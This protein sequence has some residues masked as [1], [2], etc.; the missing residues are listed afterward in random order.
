MMSHARG[1]FRA[2]R[3]PI[4]AAMFVCAAVAAAAPGS[5][6]AESTVAEPT[7]TDLAGGIAF[8]ES[9]IRPILVD[10]CYDCHA[11]DTE[12]KGSLLLDTKAGVLK[13]GDTGPVMVP[14]DPTTSLIIQ[15]VKQQNDHLK[16][17]PDGRLSDDEIAA[18]EEW[19]KMGAPDPRN[20]ARALT[21][22]E[23]HLEDAKTHWAFQPVVDPEAASLDDL[24][25]TTGAAPAD[26]RTL[27]RR[28]FL[29]LVGV[30]PTFAE[31]EAF[32]SDTSPQA[33]ERL[34]DRLL[35]DSRYG[36]R[37]G[38][39]WLDVARYADNGGANGGGEDTMP[40]AWTYR[41]YVVQAFN[42]DKPFDRF[43]QEQI[44]ADQLDTASDP[45][46]LAGL[47]FLTI[48]WRKDYK[49]DDDTLDNAL[50][51][52]GR[53]ILGLTIS[54]AR[55]HDH[56]LEPITTKDYYGLFHV[57]K[58]CR[59]PDSVPVL[60]QADS[61]EV[62]EFRD[63]NL[64]LRGEYARLSIKSA[65]D[66]THVARGRLG[67][68]LV[69]A[70]ESGWKNQYQS[71]NV[72]DLLVKRNLN[73]AIHGWFVNSRKPWIEQHP[74][75]F[76]P[77]LE[78][79]TK[80]KLDPQPVLHRLVAE[81]FA[82][83]ADTLV[84]VGRRYNEIFA[85]VDG[86]WRAQAAV[87]IAMPVELT[88]HEVEFYGSDFFPFVDT[89]QPSFFDRLH[90]LEDRLPLPDPM[91]ESLRQVLIAKAS[92]LRFPTEQIRSPRIIPANDP[93]SAKINEVVKLIKEHPGAP[94]RPMVFSD[95]PKPV[96]G[97]VYVR[98]NPA[99]AG[100]EAPR[101]FISVLRDV[102]PE[103]FPKDSSGRLEL[104]LAITSR[105]NP[106]T[107]RVIVN[108][109]WAWHFGT[110]LVST[111]SD[112]GFQGEK[113][114]NPPL[115]DHLAAWF[116]DHGWS[117][118]QMH[119]Y[120][121]LTAGYQR[122]DFPVRPLEIE[123]FRDSLLAVSG[124][125][126]ATPFGKSVRGKSDTR[127]TLYGY[128]D[129]KLLPSLYRSFDFPNPTFSNAQ[130]SRSVLV[131][132][133]LILMNSP[134]LVES[135]KALAAAITTDCADDT[136]RVVE[137]YRRVLQRSPDDAEVRS[138]LAYMAAYPPNDLVHPE[139]Q[140][141]QY[142]YGAF[143]GEG[144][145]VTTFASIQSFDGKAFKTSATSGDGKT[146]GVMVDAMG[147]DAGPGAGLSSIRRWVA[148]HDGTVTITAELTHPDTKTEGVIAR[149]IS[150]RTGQL[151]EWQAL[152]QS[153][154][155]N[156]EGVAVK[157]GD[158]IDFVVSSQTDKD[159]GPYRWS[160]SILMP[161]MEMPSMPGM[162]RRWDARTDFADP[163]KP[164]KPLTALEELCQAILLSPEFAVLE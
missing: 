31:V 142:G 67:E 49:I 82:T 73:G 84:E 53:G 112:F 159:A 47:A 66:A 131:P 76:G 77:Y 139:S 40:F 3:R 160:P 42:D 50:D 60:P 19:V 120:L 101:Q 163:A 152:G 122:A 1:I 41:D 29:D 158:T 79:I 33:F 57:L 143:D 161:G 154:V 16:M 99:I 111:P 74:E 2:V 30:P 155:T 117:L 54:C 100:P 48:G 51:T 21:K 6:A 80:Q 93:S 123:P 136:S 11:A 88:P 137:L 127:R 75:V 124:R 10:N 104:A 70:E 146:G 105:D 45:R 128:V 23:Q 150:S 126:D 78:F 9:K 96:D 72:P 55:C 114:A 58:S 115:L 90:A 8:F 91:L 38:R 103:P 24:A 81:A 92:P 18:L 52:I 37:W 83:P 110:P 134:L 61:P 26:R 135:A 69:L 12:Q 4:W 35:A 28:A 43:V 89:Y 27:I 62:R 107:P 7:A 98:G 20:G 164:P 113:P 94:P 153:V 106:L 156:L 32:V 125:L 85:M 14:G 118:K 141:W 46:T 130:R 102:A 121:M 151:G 17:P 149:V 25:G 119:R 71:K 65:S 132:R 157:Q 148:P 87:Q 5:R 13:G 36:E 144:K 59:E 63:K 22:I 109:I 133:A 56:K 116:M 34:V 68:Y 145:K 162:P 39:H 138:A 108:R 86:L 129:R 147:G 64:V 15:A 95:A 44:A 140:D 97:H